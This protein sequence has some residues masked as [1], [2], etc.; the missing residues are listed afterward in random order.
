MSRRRVDIEA[1][2]FEALAE[3][4]TVGPAAENLMGHPATAR[5]M[6]LRGELFEAAFG[7]PPEPT[8]PMMWDMAREEGGPHAVDA[9]TWLRSLTRRP[10]E[11]PLLREQLYAWFGTGLLVKDASALPPSARERWESAVADYRAYPQ[12]LDRLMADADE[13]DVEA[14]RLLAE[15][16]VVRELSEL[17]RMALAWGSNPTPFS[18]R[19]LREAGRTQQRA[20]RRCGNNPLVHENVVTAAFR[21]DDR[22]TALPRMMAWSA[23]WWQSTCPTVYLTAPQASAL[24]LRDLSPEQLTEVRAPWEAF[25][26]TISPPLRGSAPLRVMAASQQDRWSLVTEEDERTLCAGWCSAGMLHKPG[27]VPGGDLDPDEAGR[28][29]HLMGRLV[30]NLCYALGDSSLR[31]LLVRRKVKQ[32]GPKGQRR[33]PRPSKEPG[34]QSEYVFRLPVEVDLTTKVESYLS[35]H[36]NRIHQARWITRG[37]WKMQ[38]HGPRSSLRKRI[39]RAPYECNR[40]G[41]VTILREMTLKQ[42]PPGDYNC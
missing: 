15:G 37:H 3:L 34:R 5:V 22:T 38:P 19:E 26:I 40:Q 16:E 4:G 17:R 13:A 42:E 41:A 29:L 33:K 1:E 10:L 39:W 7:R 18:L 6:G 36:S 31:P 8:D 21:L 12:L 9:P 25:C 28:T 35:G 2:L 27:R 14:Q 32:R 23:L 11:R 20:Y 30:L 24:A